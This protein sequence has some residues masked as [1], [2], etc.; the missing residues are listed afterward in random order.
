VSCNTD[1]HPVP[2]LF[3]AELVKKETVG[4]LTV[5]KAQILKHYSVAGI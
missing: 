4:K 1:S 5:A 2:G 3:Q